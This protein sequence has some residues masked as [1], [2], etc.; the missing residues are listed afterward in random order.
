MGADPEKKIQIEVIEDGK[1]VYYPG[2]A[3]DGESVK[4]FIDK[5]FA[6]SADKFSIRLQFEFVDE[7][8][9]NI[10]VSIMFKN[11]IESTYVAQ[12]TNH[13]KRGIL[14]ISFDFPLHG[15]GRFDIKAKNTACG[16]SLLSSS[17]DSVPYNI[18][19]VGGMIK[20]DKV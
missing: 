18:A 3:P 4:L 16:T 7:A 2:D 10:E 9:R 6:R 14:K 17:L 8:S 1:A 15:D 13:K 12:V 11:G 20:G 19:V 5:H